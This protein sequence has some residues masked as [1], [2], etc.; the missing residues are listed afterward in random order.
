V[1]SLVR[2]PDAL[3][4]ACQWPQ[5]GRVAFLTRVHIADDRSMTRTGEQESMQIG[6]RIYLEPNTS[7]LSQKFVPTNTAG[8][9]YLQ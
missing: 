6:A 5:K 9:A 3:I 7:V 4:R 8:C 2:N 1:A